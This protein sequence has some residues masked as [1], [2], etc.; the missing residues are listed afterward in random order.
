[1]FGIEGEKMSGKKG[2]FMNLFCF[3]FWHKW[4]VIHKSQVG[5][6]I[7]GD[8]K[9]IELC[10]FQCKRCKR[11]TYPKSYHDGN[12]SIVLTRKK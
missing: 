4:Q 9:S 3:L 10:F 11:I 12:V 7:E 6:A 2:D 1:M 8:Q 5:Y